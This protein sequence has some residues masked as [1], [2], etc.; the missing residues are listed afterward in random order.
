MPMSFD[1]ED[2]ENNDADNE[3]PVDNDMDV[4]DITGDEKVDD[5][6]ETNTE[7]EQASP[8]LGWLNY[9]SSHPPSEDRIARFRNNTK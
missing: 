6:I 8:D 2:I 1:D 4:S 7:E 5:T 9:I 3:C